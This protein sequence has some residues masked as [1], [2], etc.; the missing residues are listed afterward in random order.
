MGSEEIHNT[1]Q[2]LNELKD[3]QNRIRRYEDESGYYL[4]WKR[5]PDWKDIA[6]A[7][8]IHNE[9]QDSLPPKQRNPNEEYL[10]TYSD[11]FN[12]ATHV[13]FPETSQHYIGQSPLLLKLKEKVKKE[14]QA[15]QQRPQA[16]QHLDEKYSSQEIIFI[17]T[18]GT[19]DQC[20]RALDL[21]QETF[22]SQCPKSTA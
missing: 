2:R 1:E 13:L 22:R 5:S 9:A 15:R 8:A 12:L 19:L 17:S 20:V 21:L 6:D 14:F 18:P 7:S 10:L 16:I 3:F 11:Q 4:T